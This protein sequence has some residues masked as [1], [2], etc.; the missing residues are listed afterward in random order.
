MRMTPLDVQSHRFSRRLS[1][2]DR[3][4]VET[5]LRM[6][7]EDF[8]ALLRENELQT[9]HIRRLER[10][11]T[12]LSNTEKLLKETLISA[13]AMS[14]DIRQSAVKESEVLISETELRAEKIIEAS[15]RRAARIE[16]EIREMRGM[17]T[18]MAS[19]LRAAIQTHLALIESLEESPAGEAEASLELEER[20]A[21]DRGVG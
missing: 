8:E 20:L 3:D 5:F 7:A 14:D 9:D 11:V 21:T 19:S 1:G 13:Q 2:F 15:H 17:R 12:E 18:R 4:E 16:E 10:R 6:V